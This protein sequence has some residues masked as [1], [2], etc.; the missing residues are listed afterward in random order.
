MLDYKTS[1]VKLTISLRISSKQ[2][3]NCTNKRTTST[4][5]KNNQLQI[6]KCEDFLGIN[7][8]EVAFSLDIQNNLTLFEIE[9]DAL[10][11][12]EAELIFN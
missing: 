5:I 8:S 7:T 1:S 12:K 9:Q 11:V 10:C 6:F 3:R 4:F 2:Y